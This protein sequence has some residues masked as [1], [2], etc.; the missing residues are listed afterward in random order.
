[1]AAKIDNAVGPV[2]RSGELAE[3]VIEA[4][5]LDNPGKEIDVLD[6]HAYL[7]VSVERE[8]IV[9]RSTLEQCLGRA[10]G[11]QQIEPI[12]GS[13]SGQIETTEDYL[14]FYLER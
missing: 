5:R 7:R 14:R 2:L 1:M 9:R 12:L 13:F 8:C 3:A 10:I 4:I 11:M 6:R